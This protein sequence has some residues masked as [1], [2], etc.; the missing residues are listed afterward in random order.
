MLRLSKT[1]ESRFVESRRYGSLFWAQ[2]PPEIWTGFLPPTKP[3]PSDI[4]PNMSTPRMPTGAVIQR[5]PKLRRACSIGWR[6]TTSLAPRA[7]SRDI[8]GDIIPIVQSRRHGVAV[9]NSDASLRSN[10]V[11][12]EEITQYWPIRHLGHCLDLGD[13]N[14][15]F[16][17]EHSGATYPNARDD[18]DQRRGF[19]I[20][21]KRTIGGGARNCSATTTVAPGTAPS[22]ET[23]NALVASVDGAVAEAAC[24]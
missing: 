22:T 7:H 13:E 12:D 16:V 6:Q 3:S 10:T 11:L 8:G 9:P 21:V 24:R 14:A 19:P 20:R 5:L 15:T 18:I 1:D 4:R 23:V 17:G 2:C